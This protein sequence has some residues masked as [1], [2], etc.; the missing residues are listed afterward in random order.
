M[1]MTMEGIALR[2]RFLGVDPEEVERLLSER[3]LELGQL[4]RQ[5]RVAEERA[6]EAE[7]RWHALEKRV[8][9]SEQRALSAEHELKRLQSM[10][11]SLGLE[12]ARREQEAEVLRV[13]ADDLRR[14]LEAALA[15]GVD[16]G[17]EGEHGEPRI[18]TAT[19]FLVTQVAP[20][21]RAAEESAAMVLRQA[22]AASEQERAHLD[23]ARGELQAQ[24]GVITSWWNDVHH[25]LNPIQENLSAARKTIEDIGERVREAL[26]PLSGLIGTIGQ[27]LM[28]L[29]QISSPPIPSEPERDLTPRDERAPAP[30]REGGHTGERLTVSIEEQPGER[31]SETEQVS[32]APRTGRSTWWPNAERPRRETGL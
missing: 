15:R 20:I 23:E 8:I 28:K 16:I 6:A 27:E 31:R 9:E 25:V 19:N 21:L 10:L 14:Q 1:A 32:A 26:F 3:E 30:K 7:G 24:L 29:S 22:R 12:L 2:R 5:A 11:S 17:F 18:D 4:T 13:E